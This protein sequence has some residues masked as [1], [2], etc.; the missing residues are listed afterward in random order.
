M[1]TETTAGG[2][3][4]LRGGTSTGV[5]LSTT[6]AYAQIPKGTRQ[7][8]VTPRNF[9]TGVAAKVGLCPYV[10]VLKTVDAGA[11]VMTDY[12]DAAQDDS[13]GTSVVLSSLSTAA[14]FDFLYVGAAVPFRG[15][16][17]DIDGANGNASIL[18]VKFWD[19]NSWEDIT[20]TDGTASGGASMAVDGS[21]TW[22]IPS[23]WAKTTLV[24]SG[25]YPFG[26]PF[27][28]NSLY[29]TRW[30]FSAAL[31][32]STTLDHLIALPRST[33]YFELV[34]GQSFEQSITQGPEG[35]AAVEALMDAGTGSLVLGYGGRFV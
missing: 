29:W 17:I 5:P 4:E 25:D 9:V 32:S 24:Q 30:Q 23:D 15:A 10:Q 21:V 16:N 14:A 22:T 26:G 8:F 27:G 13:T 28:G 6:A 33:A 2:F 20:A 34:A 31:D 3:G 19:G 7:L 12:S 11:T 18:T 35:V 1:T